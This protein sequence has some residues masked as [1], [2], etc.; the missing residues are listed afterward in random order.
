MSSRGRRAGPA[1]G[2]RA[3]DPAVRCRFSRRGS[4]EGVRRP[5]RSARGPRAGKGRDAGPR[6]GRGAAGAGFPEPR[7]P[8]EGGLR[9]GARPSALRPPLCI[10]Q[11]GS[12]PPLWGLCTRTLGTGTARLHW[13]SVSNFRRLLDLSPL[14]VS[15]II[16]CPRGVVSPRVGR[17]LCGCWR[18]L[19]GLASG[20]PEVRFGLGS[21]LN[22]VWMPA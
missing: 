18:S 11:V 15:V 8:A 16:L 2:E 1:L 19:A 7:P 13:T 21:K 20:S 14:P 12:V 5:P 6:S 17:S 22:W 9:S 10:G 3:S 4:G